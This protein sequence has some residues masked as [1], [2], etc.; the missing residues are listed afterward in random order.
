MLID[1]GYAIN[2]S[3]IE[4]DEAND[5]FCLHRVIL[6]LAFACYAGSFTAIGLMYAH[7]SMA[8]AFNPLAI[9]TTLALL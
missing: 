7:F 3:L 4:K 8:C 1:F 9:T 2:A 6:L 5:S